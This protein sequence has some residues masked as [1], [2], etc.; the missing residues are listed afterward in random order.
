MERGQGGR[1]INIASMNATVIGNS[2][3]GTTSR[4]ASPRPAWRI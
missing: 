1:I 4:I 3:R 2:P